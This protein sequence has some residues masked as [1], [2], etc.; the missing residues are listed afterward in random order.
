MTAVCPECDAEFELSNVEK[1][2]IVQC[3][4]CGVELEREQPGLAQR[5]RQGGEQ[6]A[7]DHRRRDVEPVEHADA[8]P[9][10]VA[11]EEDDGRECDGLDQVESEGGHRPN[12]GAQAGSGNDG[13]ITR[14]SRS[15]TPSRAAHTVR[16]A[17]SSRAPWIRAMACTSR[18]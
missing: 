8:A 16:C 7:A 17:R 10:A 18:S 2:E 6:E 12:F 15:V 9:H 13:P 3:P 1:G 14:S 5:E 4:E 11:D